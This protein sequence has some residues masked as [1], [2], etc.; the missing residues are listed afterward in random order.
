MASTADEQPRAGIPGRAG[1]AQVPGPAAVV[2]APEAHLPAERRLLIDGC[3]IALE[4]ALGVRHTVPWSECEAVLCWPDRAELVLGPELSLIIRTADWH[5]GDEALRALVARAPIALVVPMPDDPEPEPERYVLRGLAT[6]SGAALALLAI[7]PAGVAALAAAVGLAERRPSALLVAL[8]ALA[9]TVTA[10]MAL[11]RRL[12]VPARWRPGAVVRGR[13]SVHLDS[14]TARSSV[15]G[16]GLVLLLTVGVIVA[17][18]AWALAVHRPPAGF[19]VGA[20]LA[21]A[22]A[23]VRELR[24]RGR[25]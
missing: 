25:D 23:V 2:F 12:A 13:A 20:G 18:V 4:A 6:S 1:A 15:L 24:R 7:G 16:L 19:L 3:G 14:A 5:R 9:V 22:A 10:T 17:D 21:V 8:G 11:V